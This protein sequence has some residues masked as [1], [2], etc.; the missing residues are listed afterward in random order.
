MLLRTP[1][2]GFSKLVEVSSCF[3]VTIT[4]GLAGLPGEVGEKDGTGSFTTP[5][6]FGNG[7]GPVGESVRFACIK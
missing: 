2:A 3:G 1:S 7:G 4:G 6:L 5:G